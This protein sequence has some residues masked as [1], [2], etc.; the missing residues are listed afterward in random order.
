MLCV[1]FFLALCVGTAYFM[2]VSDSPKVSI[3]TGEV[4][5]QPATQE[6]KFEPSHCVI[7]KEE[8]YEL[9]EYEGTI[10]IFKTGTG[11]KATSEEELNALLEDYCS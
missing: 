11:I 1:A 8:N 2:E 9:K 4:K 6:A 3:S 7:N 5:K 10:A